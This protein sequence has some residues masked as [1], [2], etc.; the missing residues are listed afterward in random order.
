M[1]LTI[2]VTAGAMSGRDSAMNATHTTFVPLYFGVAGMI[3][4]FT[5]VPLS[6]AEPVV[7]SGN[8]PTGDSFICQL[9]KASAD[10]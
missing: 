1:I 7:I 3:S 2:S 10:R 4:V 9:M 8:C 6:L 5:R